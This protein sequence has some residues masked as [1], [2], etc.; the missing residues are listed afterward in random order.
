MSEVRRSGGEYRDHAYN[1]PATVVINY[2]AEQ[3]LARVACYCGERELS[4]RFSSCY[5]LYSRW[6]KTITERSFVRLRE[7]CV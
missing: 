2:L 7:L 4:M 1:V 6:D 5:S 3:G